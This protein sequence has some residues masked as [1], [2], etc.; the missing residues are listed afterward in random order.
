MFEERIKGII[1]EIKERDKTSSSSSTS[2]HHH[3]RGLGARRQL[4]RRKHCSSRRLARGEIRIV[5]ATTLT[6]YRNTSPRTSAARRFRLVKVDDRRSTRPG[7]SCRAS[8]TGSRKLLVQITDEAIDKA[9]E[10]APRYIRRL[11]SPPR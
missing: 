1:N 5:G 9:L 7:R 4:G 2:A 3:R 6:E 8:A 11:H 10:M